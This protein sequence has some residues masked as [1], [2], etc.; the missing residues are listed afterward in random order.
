MA[1]ILEASLERDT[2]L[3]CH[4]L[5]LAAMQ[6]APYVL[7]QPRPEAPPAQG[8]TA[9]RDSSCPHSSDLATL[10]AAFNKWRKG[11]KKSKAGMERWFSG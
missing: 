2:H 9:V 1:G 8:H 10:E 6:T 5:T 7:P 11:K 4:S 3:W